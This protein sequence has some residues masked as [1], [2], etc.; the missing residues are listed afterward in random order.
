MQISLIHFDMGKFLACFALNLFRFLR[1]K[2]IYKGGSLSYVKGN[3][4]PM[5]NHII[6]NNSLEIGKPYKTHLVDESDE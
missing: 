3:P 2:N 5:I 4:L 1:I 6:E